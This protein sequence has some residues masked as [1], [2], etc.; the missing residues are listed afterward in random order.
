MKKILYSLI[1]VLAATFTACEDP[2]T[3]ILYTEEFLELDAATTVTGSRTYS[4]LRVNDGQG[5]PSGFIVNLGAAQ[6]SSPVN[7]TFEI[8]VANS[9]A[10]ENLHYQVNSTSGTIQAN[11]STAELPITIL[12]DNINP[13]ENLSLIVRLT[14]GDVA[15]NPN[16]ETATH[17]LQVLCES[18]LG[19]MYT[20]V[21]TYHTHDFLPAF[22][23]NTQDVELVDDGGG[24][25][26]LVGFD[27]G[28]YDGGPYTDNYGTGAVTGKIQDVCGTITTNGV[29]DPWQNLL[30][31]P[32]RP[33]SYDPA[34][35]VITYSVVG[36]VYGEN[37]T[38]VLT[39]K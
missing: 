18:N 39:P 38:S 9:T 15:I 16:Y 36:D 1:V 20:M 5:V 21:T 6:S 4:Y 34:T 30:P 22:D 24:N 28:L 25:Y 7:Y 23:A 32:A 33:N 8:D 14:G 3:D 19:G 13:G 10:I 2:G 26:T 11:S 29:Q 31:D 27:G 12:D 37:W 17:N 35:G